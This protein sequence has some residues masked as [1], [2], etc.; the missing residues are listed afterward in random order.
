MMMG[1]ITMMQIT[2]MQIMV[3]QRTVMLRQIMV[4]QIRMML[5]LLSRK[6]KNQPMDQIGF[7]ADQEYP[8]KERRNI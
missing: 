3:M 7:L 4:M 2:V 5:I 1:Q 6:L 8:E